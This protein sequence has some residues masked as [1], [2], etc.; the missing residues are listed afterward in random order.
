MIIHFIIIRFIYV[1]LEVL[2]TIKSDRKAIRILKAKHQVLCVF[3][4]DL[5][6]FHT[7]KMFFTLFFDFI[8]LNFLPYQPHFEIIDFKKF[9]N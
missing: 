4:H 9:K 5:F 1:L 3:Y 7:S 8:D 6:N 2:D